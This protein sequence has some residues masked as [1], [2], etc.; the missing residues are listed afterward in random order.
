MKIGIFE[1]SDATKELKKYHQFAIAGMKRV[2]ENNNLVAALWN[3]TRHGFPLGGRVFDMWTNDN[4]CVPNAYKAFYGNKPYQTIPDCDYHDME[5]LELDDDS[6][7]LNPH[8]DYE[9]PLIVS[10]HGN[11]YVGRTADGKF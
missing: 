5:E 7:D 9:L 10:Y 8:R 1:V 3:P 4:P 2:T 11:L 6:I